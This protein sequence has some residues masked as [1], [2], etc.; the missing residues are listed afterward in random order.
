[1]SE[2]SSVLEVELTSSC[3]CV[4]YDECDKEQPSEECFGCWSDALEDLDHNLLLP[5]LKAVDADNGDLISVSGSGLGWM[6]Q[7]GSNAFEL[8]YDDVQEEII[9]RLSLNGD[10]RL[11][12]KLEG[13][14]FSARR[15][16]HDEPMGSAV[17]VFRLV[18]R[19]EEVM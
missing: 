10:F 1:M 14:V 17:F 5:W 8:D 11:V 16:S 13:D 4:T 12:F 7:D 15:W 9:N 18:K 3:V 2:V 19:V 6:R